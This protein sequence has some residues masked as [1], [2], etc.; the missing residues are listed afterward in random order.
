MREPLWLEKRISMNLAWGP[1]Q[2]I[3]GSDLS[4]THVVTGIERHSLRVAVREEVLSLSLLSNAMRE[5]F[6]SGLSCTLA[7]RFC[8]ER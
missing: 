4:P 3:R 2:S 5:C 1:I 6:S 8:I 7:E